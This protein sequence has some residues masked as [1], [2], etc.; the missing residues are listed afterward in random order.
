MTKTNV[1]LTVI[2]ACAL[3]VSGAVV[4]DRLKALPVAHPPQEFVE[5]VANDKARSDK[6]EKVRKIHIQR[7]PYCAWC[8]GTT[9]LQV[10]HIRPFALNPELHGS[11]ALGGELDD[12]VDGTGRDGNLITL[13]M[14]PAK[15]AKTPDEADHHERYG[16]GG[17]FKGG[18]NLK[19]REECTAHEAAMRSKGLWPEAHECTVDKDGNVICKR[20]ER[21]CDEICNDTNH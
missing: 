17:H 6:W 7:E 9:N 14:I 3:A 12:G 19:V 13:C 10:H 18:E 8:G 11:T 20:K 4:H 15:E 21:G 16:H 5:K 2:G 1:R